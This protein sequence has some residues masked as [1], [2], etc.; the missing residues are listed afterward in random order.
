M[1][2]CHDMCVLCYLGT[3]AAQAIRRMLSEVYSSHSRLLIRQVDKARNALVTVGWYDT[4][5]QIELG[6]Q[7]ASVVGAAADPEQF[8]GS[9]AGSVGTRLRAA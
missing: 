3:T 1:Q 4:N 9:S 8:I 7:P 5:G 6:R 2:L